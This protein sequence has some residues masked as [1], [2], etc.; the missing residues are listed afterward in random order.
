[1][2]L[3]SIYGTSSFARTFTYNVLFRFTGQHTV[4]CAKEKR[5]WGWWRD[6]GND[7]DRS[8]RRMKRVSQ[9]STHWQIPPQCAY[10][11]R[12]FAKATNTVR[13]DC[14][15]ATGWLASAACISPST[16]HRRQLVPE[17][18]ATDVKQLL[19][20]R[21]LL[22]PA[23]WINALLSGCHVWIRRGW[24]PPDSLQCNIPI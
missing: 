16:N 8:Q 22:Q 15:Q 9:E 5:E 14:I 13:D 6:S 4:E 21:E 24:G 1:M 10:A 12:H 7:A 20:N 11:V 3:T 2:Y 18:I 17:P 19:F 23:R